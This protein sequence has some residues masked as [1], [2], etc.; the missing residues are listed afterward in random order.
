MISSLRDGRLDTYARGVSITS[1]S[2]A[3]FNIDRHTTIRGYIE[4][5]CN[6][7]VAH[8]FGAVLATGTTEFRGPYSYIIIFADQIDNPQFE[9]GGKPIKNARIFQSHD[10]LPVVVRSG[11]VVV[12]VFAFQRT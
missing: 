3:T 11:R 12:L 1:P 5:I 10:V 7:K 4:K 2:Y 8:T 9:V 6:D